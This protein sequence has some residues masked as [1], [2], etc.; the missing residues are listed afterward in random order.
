MRMSDVLSRHTGL[1]SWLFVAPMKRWAFTL[2][3]AATVALFALAALICFLSTPFLSG[4]DDVRQEQAELP[5][6]CVQRVSTGGSVLSLLYRNTHCTYVCTAVLLLPVRASSGV[7]APHSRARAARQDRLIAQERA[8]AS[9]KGLQ[10]QLARRRAA[11]LRPADCF[12]LADG[13]CINRAAEASRSG[14]PHLVWY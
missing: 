7:L 9:T 5:T 11:I 8:R 4:R 13:C 2:R 10:V 6:R 12:R 3:A 1:R 14:D